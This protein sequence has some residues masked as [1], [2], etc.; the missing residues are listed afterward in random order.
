MKTEDELMAKALGQGLSESLMK[1]SGLDLKKSS[2]EGKER[3]IQ[4]IRLFDVLART[5][6]K[7]H[8]GTEGLQ[9]LGMEVDVIMGIGPVKRV[10]MNA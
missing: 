8:G 7:T 10:D 5:V 4:L 6:I 1:D 2:E 9:K 3:S